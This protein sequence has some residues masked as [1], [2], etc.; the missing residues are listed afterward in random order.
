MND[1]DAARNNFASV[2]DNFERDRIHKEVGEENTRDFVYFTLGFSRM[3]YA[4]VARLAVIK[5]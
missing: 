4:S 1:I 3:V 2:D 5:V